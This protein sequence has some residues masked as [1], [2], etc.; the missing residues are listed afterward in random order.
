MKKI[1]I[2]LLIIIAAILITGC[3]GDISPAM[4]SSD[5]SSSDDSSSGGSSSGD[6]SSS[7][8]SNTFSLPDGERA[9]YDAVMNIT[10][11]ISA[12]SS[13]NSSLITSRHVTTGWVWGNPTYEIFNAFR[14]Y[15]FP[16]DEGVIDTSNVYKLL[17]EANHS[18]DDAVREVVELPELT[19]I[20]SPFDFG[21]VSRSYTHASSEYAL[22]EDG[23]TV[24]ALLTWIWDEDPKFSYGVFEGSFDTITGDV[25]V[26]M[27]YLVDYPPGGNPEGEDGD[28]CLRTYISGNEDTHFFTLRTSK[29]GTGDSYYAISMIGTGISR[30]DNADDYFLMKII[31]NDNLSGYPDGRYFKFPASADEGDLI[32]Y[33]VFGYTLGEIDDPDNYAEILDGLEFFSLDG[34][35]HATSTDDFLNSDLI[36]EY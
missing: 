9:F 3:G 28:Y 29:V 8:D 1:I 15:E 27:V 25:E 19:V 35:D 22:S 16:R 23:D 32:G 4:T 14:E 2:I 34:S 33:S 6:S 31:D 26:D 5:D 36:L 11:V 18:Y 24:Y 20:D 10:P 7:D 30:S 21:A 13:E 12:T 17:F